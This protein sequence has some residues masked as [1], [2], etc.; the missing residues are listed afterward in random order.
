MTRH[1]IDSPWLGGTRRV[2]VWTPEHRNLGTS[3]PRPPSCLILHDGQNLF[4][5]DRAHRPGHHWH[6]AE[7]VTALTADG[8][9]PPLVVAGID[10]A[11][12]QRLREL[13]PSDGDRAG[14]D[15]WRYGR[16]VMEDLLP[17][18]VDEYGVD[19]APGALAMG[20]SSLG[21]LVT[22]VLAQQYP[23]RFG[24]LLVMSPSIWWD[25]ALILRRLR[26]QPLVPATRVWLD[27]GHR[28]GREAL[29][30]VRRLRRLLRD[31]LDAGQLGGT[32]EAQ[33]DHTEDSW[34]RR[35]PD[36][37]TWLYRDIVDTPG[38]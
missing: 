7:T 3:A 20:G 10:H 6:V 8:L 12:E 28:E 29:H 17:F 24:R 15:A 32:E 13:T 27:I 11:G 18:L 31:Q 38:G 4:D 5:P 1:D 22:L 36:A 9:L 23:G 2:T 14:G 21:G 37:L 30:N 26:R 25:R 16:F 34:A 33:G 19:V 35:L